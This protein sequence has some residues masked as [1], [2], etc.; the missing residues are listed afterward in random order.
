MDRTGNPLADALLAKPLEV[1]NGSIVL[2]QGPG[3]GIELND[4]TVAGYAI[5]QGT[6]ALPGNCSDMVFA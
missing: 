6:L 3:L 1:T 2:P 4:E 5:P